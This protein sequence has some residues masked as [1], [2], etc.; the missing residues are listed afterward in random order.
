[1]FAVPVE[2][3]ILDDFLSLFDSIKLTIFGGQIRSISA[4]IPKSHYEID[5]D[6]M[7]N[8]EVIPYSDMPRNMA[9]IGVTCVYIDDEWKDAT[10]F[11]I[12]RNERSYGFNLGKLSQGTY[13]IK[14]KIAISPYDVDYDGCKNRVNHCG[15]VSSPYSC[16]YMV[17]FAEMMPCE[18]INLYCEEKQYVREDGSTVCNMYNIFHETNIDW[19][20]YDIDWYVQTEYT[21]MVIVGE[22]ECVYDL[23]CEYLAEV[24][25]YDGSFW[26]HDYECVEGKCIISENIPPDSCLYSPTTSTT[27]TTVVTTTT[28]PVKECFTWMDCI[29]EVSILD[30]EGYWSCEDGI[31]RYK[32]EDNWGEGILNWFKKGFASLLGGRS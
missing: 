21:E 5:E 13:N 24:V 22:A 6:V 28:I 16:P 19:F 15:W 4:D 8:V 27:T 18:L 23:E 25:C 1:M 12:A 7:V 32:C 10:G 3:S 9:G 29:H 14:T 2:A 17:T 20:E 31:C 30:C 26:Y 11:K